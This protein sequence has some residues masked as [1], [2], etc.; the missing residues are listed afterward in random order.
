[1]ISNTNIVLADVHHGDSASVSPII[2]DTQSIMDARINP[3]TAKQSFAE[4]WMKTAVK[5][6]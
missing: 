5:Q 1:M 6:G 4:S 3:E 2:A